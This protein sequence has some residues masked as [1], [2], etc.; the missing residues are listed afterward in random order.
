MK[1]KCRLRV[2]L[3]EKDM[4]HEDLRQMVGVSRGTLSQIINNKTVPNF[5]TAYRI[6]EALHMRIEDIWTHDAN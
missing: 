5:D 4:Q 2:I 6:A 3:A 1:Y